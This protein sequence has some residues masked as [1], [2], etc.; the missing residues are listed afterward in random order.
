MIFSSP[1]QKR[2]YVGLCV[3][4]STFGFLVTMRLEMFVSRDVLTECHLRDSSYVLLHR[5]NL[6]K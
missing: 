2:D 1:G 3:Y 5:M 6:E 4:G